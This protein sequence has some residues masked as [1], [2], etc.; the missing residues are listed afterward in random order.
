VTTVGVLIGALALIVLVLFWSGRYGRR[1]RGSGT[2][3]RRGPNAH[4]TQKGRPKMAYATRAEATARARLL[5]QRD[6][7]SMG[8]YQC[9]TCA[10]WHVGHDK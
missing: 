5:T 3:L 6:G 9:A 7:A 4:T 1:G 2:S 8:V 10:K